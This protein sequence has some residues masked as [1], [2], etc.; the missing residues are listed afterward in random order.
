MTETAPFQLAP[1]S[2]FQGPLQSR[3]EGHRASVEDTEAI[4]SQLRGRALQASARDL[5]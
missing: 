3:H 2:Q 4:R 5:I 1:W